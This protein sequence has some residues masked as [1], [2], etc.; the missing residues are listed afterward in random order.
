MLLFYRLKYRLLHP[1][2]VGLL[3]FMAVLTVPV[4]ASDFSTY[5]EEQNAAYRQDADEFEEENEKI[6][7]EFEAYQKKVRAAYREYRRSVSAIWGKSNSVISDR[8]TWAE[9]SDD[10]K[11]RHVVD[12]KSGQVTVE[13]ILEK[14]ETSPEVIKKKLR[15]AVVKSVT[16]EADS[17]SIIELAATTKASKKSPARSK[18]VE[19]DTNIKLPAIKSKPKKTLPVLHQQ[20]KTS[21]GKTVT[22]KNARQFAKET[23]K[24]S[25]AVVKT[26]GTDGKNRRVAKS[27]YQLVPDHIKKRAIRFKGDVDRYSNR[28]GVSKNLVYAVI[29][30]ESYFNPVA[31]SNAPAYGLMQLVPHYGA[32]EAYRHVYK[33]DKVV[34][35]NYLYNPGNNIQL[36]SAY[37][38]VLNKIR[39]DGVKNEK[40]RLWCTIAAYNTGPSNVF[41]AVIG[42]YRRS[43]HR[44]YRIYKDKAIRQINKL[45]SD[46][47]YSLLRKQLPYSETR[48]YIKKVRSRMGK[49]TSL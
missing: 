37:L 34:S 12:F 39:M 3:V 18:P 20:V 1:F 4:Q 22:K 9:Y 10:L 21:A 24:K 43:T 14:N 5:L 13:V 40:S 6:R 33:K 35:A 27:Q 8:D 19:V 41:R 25:F 44:K 38:H 45:S 7:K 15:A 31:R 47:L 49:Y 36:G 30:T 32:R 26:K 2:I 17:R 42:K 28:Y 11:Q 29:E 46:Q 23:T 48:H 16:S